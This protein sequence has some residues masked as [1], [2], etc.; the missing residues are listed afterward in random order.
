MAKITALSL[1]IINRV[2]LKRL[3]LGIPAKRLS[4]ILEHSLNYLFVIENP[5]KEATYP[6]HEYPK[7]AASLNCE[8]HDLLPPNDM[9]QISTGSLVDKE[10]LSL[11]NKSD[12]QTVIEGL[13]AY[14]FFDQAKTTDDIVKHL[15][16][17]KK[18]QEEL[19]IDVMETIVKDGRL[20]LRVMEYY[21]DIV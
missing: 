2:K 16:I 5:N 14:G 10:V 4:K 11:G 19:L 8:I 13:I 1:Y 21:R 6:P 9:E 17:K 7:L 18:D 15:S 20:K 3:I 12:L